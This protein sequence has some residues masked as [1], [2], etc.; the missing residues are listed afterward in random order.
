MISLLGKIFYLA[1]CCGV[2]VF[3]F[4]AAIMEGPFFKIGEDI[5]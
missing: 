3:G 2:I 4:N 1:R 5:E